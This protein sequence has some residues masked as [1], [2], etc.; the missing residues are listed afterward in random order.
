MIGMHYKWSKLLLLIIISIINVVSVSGQETQEKSILFSGI[1]FSSVSLTVPLAQVNIIV[2]KESGSSS[3]DKGEFTI[4]VAPND[5]LVFSHIGYHSTTVFIP[6]SITKG[7]L[8]ARIFL[9]SD[10][11]D[12]EQV[13]INSLKDMKTL[14]IHF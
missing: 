10:T 1:V 4:K 11:V 3:N 7:K 6:D 13:V 14:R 12:L 2:N 8:I 9:V 5:T